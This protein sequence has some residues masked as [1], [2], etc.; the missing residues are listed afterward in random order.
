MNSILN[1]WKDRIYPKIQPLLGVHENSYPCVQTLTCGFCWVFNSSLPQFAWGLKGFVVVKNVFGNLCFRHSG[2]ISLNDS[3]L[4]VFL[5]FDACTGGNVL[6]YVG[7]LLLFYVPFIVLNF[8]LIYSP[9]HDYKAWN[10]PKFI[11][12]H[13]LQCI[14]WIGLFHFI[15]LCK[16]GQ[17]SCTHIYHMYV[18]C[19]GIWPLSC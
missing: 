3:L 12:E 15:Y 11:L 7:L 4:H 8:L 18:L 16:W 19:R 14:V 13:D 10:C 5:L 17:V 2:F 6:L 1:T 9:I